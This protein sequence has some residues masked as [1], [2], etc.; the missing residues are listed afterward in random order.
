[1]YEMLTGFLPLQRNDMVLTCQTQ[2]V[3]GLIYL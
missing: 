2:K 3:F 1:M